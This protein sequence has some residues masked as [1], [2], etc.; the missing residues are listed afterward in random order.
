MGSRCIRLFSCPRFVYF[1]TEKREG[2][3]SKGSG[4]YFFL[5]SFVARA[6][7]YLLLLPI[8]HLINAKELVARKQTL[9][10]NCT[11]T[12]LQVNHQTIPNPWHNGLGLCFYF[13]LFYSSWT[14]KEC[15]PPHT[16][17]NNAIMITKPSPW[18]SLCL[19]F[20]VVAS[21]IEKFV[22]WVSAKTFIFEYFLIDLH[23][24]TI[25]SGMKKMVPWL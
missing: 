19:L 24:Q 20:F 3:K 15:T 8:D 23:E 17:Q 1:A 16:T 7:A 25:E 5:I 21:C 18:L 12:R 11:N 2:I 22:R 9:I 10:W 6:I 14:S 4:F 13:I